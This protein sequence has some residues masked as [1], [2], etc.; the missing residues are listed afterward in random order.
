MARTTPCSPEIRRDRLRK[1]GQFLDAANLTAG[2]A[3]GKAE[4]ADSFITLCIHA[5]IAASD[6]IC[7]ARLGQHTQGENHTEA[8]ALLE[9]AD[10]GSGKHLRVLLSMKTKVG[11]SHTEATAADAKRAGRA[12][13]ALVETA[14]RVNAG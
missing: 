7:C 10:S 2:Q 4:N 14:R 5:G 6:V 9:K 11:Y 1:A 12:A 3:G 8:V 13:E